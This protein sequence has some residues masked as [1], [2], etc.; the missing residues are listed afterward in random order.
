MGF[1]KPAEREVQQ[2]KKARTVSVARAKPST[3]QIRK[4][5]S[6]DQ[7]DHFQD[8]NCEAEISA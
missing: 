5:R 1:A 7:V 8:L 2:I 3:N 6:F 4:V